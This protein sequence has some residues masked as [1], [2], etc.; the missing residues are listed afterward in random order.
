M[1]VPDGGLLMLVRFDI[2][3]CVLA[4]P[5]P[6]SHQL[7]YQ[8]RVFSRPCN[9]EAVTSFMYGRPLPDSGRHLYFSERP[10]PEESPQ[11]NRRV[12]HI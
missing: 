8:S 11:I 10:R 2:T 6:L 1:C 3:A 5:G 7:H 9:L 4:A 12:E